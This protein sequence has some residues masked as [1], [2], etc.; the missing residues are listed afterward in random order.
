MNNIFFNSKL[1]FKNRNIL[2]KTKIVNHT[3]N[4]PKKLKKTEKTCHNRGPPNIM[5][6]N[7]EE[8]KCHNRVP[9]Y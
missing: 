9:S 7:K 2:N 1:K 3:K 8:K 4:A 6:L 5:E